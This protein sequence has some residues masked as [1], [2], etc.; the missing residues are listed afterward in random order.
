MCYYYYT[1]EE[2]KDGIYISTHQ[3]VYVD[4]FGTTCVLIIYSALIGQYLFDG[5]TNE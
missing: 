4:V 1:K 2:W 5:R 3:T